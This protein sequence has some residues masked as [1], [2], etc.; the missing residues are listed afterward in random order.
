MSTHLWIS[1]K[2]DRA[3]T[4][5]GF[6]SLDALMEARTERS[7]GKHG[8]ATWRERVVVAPSHGLPRLFIKRYTRP[9]LK[10]QLKRVLVGGRS[11]ADIEWTSIQTLS[12]LGI[13][14][15]PAVACGCERAWLAERRS[16]LVTA[17]ITGISL[18]RRATQWLEEGGPEPH[19][20]RAILRGVAEM[21]ARLH[22]AGL[23]HRDLYLAHIFVAAEHPPIPPMTLIDLQRVF[24]PRWRFER[25]R[26]KDLAALNYS[27]PTGIASRTERLR[28]LKCYLGHE[29]L[30]SADRR[31][32]HRVVRKTARIA[33]HSRKHGLG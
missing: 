9:P 14:V 27:T 32:V 29:R 20:K 8:L 12:D 21:A 10:E 1:P 28:W 13:A 25:W 24:R 6:D 26:C 3:L 15:P 5:R 4:Q 11:T 16:V 18:E 22:G 2:F 7:L 30:T 17:E 33:R 23:V 19:T 31:L